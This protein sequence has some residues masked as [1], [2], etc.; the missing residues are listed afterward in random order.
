M[1]RR[2][3]ECLP[4]LSPAPLLPWLLSSAPR[5]PLAVLPR[6]MEQLRAVSADGFGAAAAVSA[7]VRMLPQPIHLTDTGYPHRHSPFQL[8]QVLVLQV[9]SGRVFSLSPGFAGATY[10]GVALSC[11]AACPSAHHRPSQTPSASTSNTRVASPCRRL[12]VVAAARLPRGRLRGSR[13]WPRPAAATAQ[14]QPLTPRRT[15]ACLH[16]RARALGTRYPRSLGRSDGRLLALT[17][18]T[19]TVSVY[20][21]KS[22]RSVVRAGKGGAG[23][24]GAGGS[25][26]TAE[27]VEGAPYAAG[28]GQGSGGGAQP[29]PHTK[30]WGPTPLFKFA[31]AEHVFAMGTCV[32]F[33]PGT[34]PPPS[35]F[36][37]F[38]LVY[39]M[40][41]FSAFFWRTLHDLRA[42]R[43]S[44]S[45]DP[46]HSPRPAH[47]PQS[48]SSPPSRLP[49]TG[50]N[51][52]SEATCAAAPCG[53]LRQRPRAGSQRR[54]RR[55]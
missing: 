28:Q 11:V 5:P 44:P 40:S 22:V 8:W 20:A 46:P 1:Q 26:G 52:P 4:E 13:S 14:R 41:V 3:A 30:E 37:V 16:S 50:W 12:A 21:V 36:R 53:T 47:A 43:A 23:K 39:C 31:L 54:R 38:F 32:A 19:R 27:W 42:P 2:S 49:Q 17:G 35:C 33:S 15:P 25:S 7:A 45:P 48:R 29:E 34:P 24:G 51:W 55:V 9:K 10:E 6:R 18:R